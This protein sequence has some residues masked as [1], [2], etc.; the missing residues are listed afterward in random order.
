MPQNQP[1]RLLLVVPVLPAASMSPV[2]PM[3][4]AVPRVTTPVKM[5]TITREAFS[6]YTR[7]SWGSWKISSPFLSFM[8]TMQV[9][10][11]YMPPLARA[12]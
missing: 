4:L 8:E 11:R 7:S 5:S 1:S 6:W 12:A 2:Q 9:G 10:F 3:P